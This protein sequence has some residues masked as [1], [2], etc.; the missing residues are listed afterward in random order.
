MKKDKNAEKLGAK[1]GLAT[2]KKKGRKHFSLLAKK[3]WA[4]YYAA[5]KLSK[6]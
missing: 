2:L 3:R 4:K 6:K 5:Q 1:G